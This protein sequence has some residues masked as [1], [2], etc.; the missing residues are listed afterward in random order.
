MSVSGFPNLT[1][2]PVHCRTKLSGDEDD[3]GDDE[4]DGDQQAG[5]ASARSDGVGTRIVYHGGGHP[6]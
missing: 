5:A 2:A 1:R 4:D 6:T 3:E